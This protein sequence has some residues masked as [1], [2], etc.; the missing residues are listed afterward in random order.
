MDKV[1][2]RFVVS[3]PVRNEAAHLEFTMRSMVSQ[4]I[5]P[6]EGGIVDDGSTDRT[7][8]IIWPLSCF[9]HFAAHPRLGMGSGVIVTW[10]TVERTL[11]FAR[12]FM[13]AEPA[14]FIGASAGKLSVGCGRPPDGTHWMR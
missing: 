14:K 2:R 12:A 11:R 4:T 5:L 8:E 6:S 1:Q 10:K 9:E 3:T 13:C 7:G